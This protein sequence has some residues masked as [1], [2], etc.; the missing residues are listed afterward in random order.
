MSQSEKPGFILHKTARNYK[1]FS[2]SLK[3]VAKS[4]ALQIWQ[5]SSDL[6][7]GFENQIRYLPAEKILW[8]QSSKQDVSRWQ[9]NYLN[10]R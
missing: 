3:A 4:F 7:I 8:R 10:I 6:K 9:Q 2:F 5:L 1:A